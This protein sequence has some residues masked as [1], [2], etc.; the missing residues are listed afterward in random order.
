MAESNIYRE[1]AGEGATHE[2]IGHCTQTTL[3][4]TPNQLGGNVFHN[5]DLNFSRAA[6]TKGDDLAFEEQSQ[7]ISL[8]RR[9][10]TTQPSIEA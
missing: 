4:E 8:S 5:S 6:W 3:E 9:S 10:S 1:L 2:T 7:S